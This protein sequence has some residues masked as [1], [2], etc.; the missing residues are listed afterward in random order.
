M[1]NF[2]TWSRKGIL[3]GII[4]GEKEQ[5]EKNERMVYFMYDL[6]QFIDSPD[7]REYNKET[8]FTPAEWA[9]LVA[10]SMK[11]SVEEKIEALRYLADRYSADEFKEETIWPTYGDEG[12]C[13]SFREI[14]I[15]TVRAWEEALAARFETEGV[16]FEAYLCEQ[17]Y[18]RQ[19]AYRHYFS[20][21]EKAWAYLL[22]EKQEYLDDDDL[23]DVKTFAKINRINLDRIKGDGEN[24]LFDS[25]M[26]MVGVDIDCDKFFL[27]R[28]DFALA[29]EY[30]VYV[31]LPFKKGDI[32]KVD[33]PQTEVHYGVFS[34]DWRRPEKPERI[35]MW[36]SLEMY[37]EKERDFD[38]TD[39]DPY[40][41]DV[42]GFSFC[43]DEELPESEQ[44][45][46]LIRAVRKGDMDFYTLLHKFGRNELEDMLKWF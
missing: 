29:D 16:V 17:E 28:E 9:V 2:Y 40:W 42:L 14:V 7:I 23:K 1:R 25:E 10:K 27:E 19:R 31:P 44:V 38:Y 12:D 6:L 33:F 34:C 45:L 37:I 20:C 22:S 41:D 36:V 35:H 11:R 8:Q 43:R 21:Y 32:V 30:L 3:K 39:G 13:G 18:S 24:Y 5:S 46:K 15:E 26:R 4:S